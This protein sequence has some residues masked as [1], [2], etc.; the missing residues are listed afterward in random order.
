MPAI[1]SPGRAQAIVTPVDVYLECGAKRT[2]AAA[3]DWPG[4]CRQGP[5][6]ADAL[7][8]LLAYGPR[9]ASIVADTRLGFSA[10]SDVA[11]LVVV[12]RLT[13]TPT[14][15]FGAPGVAPSVDHDRSLSPADLERFEKILGA[16]WRAFDSAVKSARGK[17]LATGPRGG[18]RSL[19]AIVAHVKDADASYLSA[20]GWKAPKAAKPAEQLTAT[21]EAILAALKAS[22]AGEIPA[23]GPRGGARWTARYFVRRVAWH[24]MAHVWEVERRA[25]LPTT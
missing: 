8:A 16:G 14:T 17:T 12:E 20:V 21:R 23:H 5:N 15:D 19:E 4:W 2:F 9:Y 1:H 10:P 6:A 22:A 24:V 3:L 7:A 11:Q 18:G 25:G 13:G